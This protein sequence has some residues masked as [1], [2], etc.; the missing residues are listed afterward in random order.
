VTDPCVIDA[1]ATVAWCF[2][3]ETT[4]ASVALLER[5]QSAEAWVPGLWRAEVANVLLAAERRHRITRE[6]IIE[7]LTMLGGLAIRIDAELEHRI[8]GP[9][10]NLARLRRLTVYDAMYLDVAQRRGI[11]LAT[12]DRQ[13][14]DAA[15]ASGIPLIDS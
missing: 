10:L 12:R 14:R 4:P 8:N 11:P 6:L 3:D 9:V 2:V 7:F 15:V 13:L 1:S 5:L